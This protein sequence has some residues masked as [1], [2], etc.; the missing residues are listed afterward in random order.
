MSGIG[1]AIL[2]YE[3]NDLRQ[4][5]ELSAYLLYLHKKASSVRVLN[6]N[7]DGTVSDF[8]GDNAGIN[9]PLR[10]LRLAIGAVTQSP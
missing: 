5:D 9:L 6:A 2:D 10:L 7:A 3:P 4:G 1:P 8:S